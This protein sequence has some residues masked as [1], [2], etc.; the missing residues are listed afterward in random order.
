MMQSHNK[1]SAQRVRQIV[2]EEISLYRKQM[3]RENSLTVEKIQDVVDA[4]GKLQ[5]GL[6]D[7]NE[8]TKDT[9]PRLATEFTELIKQLEDK[10]QMVLKNPGDY[11]SK[12]L[13]LPA[14]N[15]EKK[16]IKLKNPPMGSSLKKTLKIQPI[17]G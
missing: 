6:M 2:N 17:K 7:F 4:L 14:E 11:I 13:D 8:K 16:S 5:L 3:L 15:P 12:D 9:N 10:I 1:I